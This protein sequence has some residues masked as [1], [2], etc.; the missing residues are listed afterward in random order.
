[1][2]EL[3]LLST[4]LLCSGCGSDQASSNSQPIQEPASSATHSGEIAT[5]KISPVAATPPASIAKLPFDLPIM[6]GAR[7]RSGSKFSKPT[8]RRGPEATATIIAKGTTTEVVEF[9]KKAL[10]ENGFT[11]KLGPVNDESSAKVLGARENGETCSVTT[12][13]GGSKAGP[14]ECQTAIIATK[15]K[16]TEEAE[17]EAGAI[18]R[19]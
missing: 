3:I 9:Y 1:M 12:M 11:A 10:I 16:P 4:L 7:Y 13:R 18:N 17:K 5:S 14:G 8:K 19:D 6:P 15:P 2:R